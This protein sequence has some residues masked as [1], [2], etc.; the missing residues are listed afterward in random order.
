M[1]P[2]DLGACA[3]I[4][5][6][7]GAESFSKPKNVENS[8]GKRSKT[9]TDHVTIFNKWSIQ[10]IVI[11]YLINTRYFFL[12]YSEKIAFFKRYKKF[13]TGWRGFI[14]F[15]P[16]SKISCQTSSWNN[17]L[18]SDKWEMFRNFAKSLKIW[19]FTEKI[20]ILIILNKNMHKNMHHRNLCK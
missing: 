2:R 11:G 17:H 18:W 1:G 6:F 7:W 14:N 13:R 8:C 16:L 15:A 19:I 3:A 12:Y 20:K 10:N 5:R 4:M 9:L